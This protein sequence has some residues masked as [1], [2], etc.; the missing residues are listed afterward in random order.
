M[1]IIAASATESIDMYIIAA[2]TTNITTVV[3]I[4]NNLI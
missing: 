1:P 2:S 4:T 3:V